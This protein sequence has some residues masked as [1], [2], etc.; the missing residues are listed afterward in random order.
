MLVFDGHFP[1]SIFSFFISLIFAFLAYIVFKRAKKISREKPLIIKKETIV[2]VPVVPLEKAVKKVEE[3]TEI[4][5]EKTEDKAVEKKYLTT[6]QRNTISPNEVDF[7]LHNQVQRQGLQ[8]LESLEIIDETK[9]IDTLSGRMDFV[10][11]IYENLLLVKDKPQYKRYVQRAIDD[12]KLMYYNKIL[13]DYQ[14]SLL[15]A[16]DIVNLDKFYGYAIYQCFARFETQQREQMNKLTRESAIQNRREKIIKIGYSAKYLFKVY[17][18]TDY[19]N[20]I[21]KIES[22]R[23]KYFYKKTIGDT[24]NSTDLQN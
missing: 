1:A 20:N 11:A 21:E 23:Q 6:S 8:V 5:T 13:K 19:D 2:R 18:I 12:Y 4:K 22:I 3:Q 14:I 9:N 17:S 16:P 7:Y 15:I 10:N 24:L